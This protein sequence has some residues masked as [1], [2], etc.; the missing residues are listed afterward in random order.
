[1][2]PNNLYLKING[3]CHGIL[4][5]KNPL[6]SVRSLREIGYILKLERNFYTSYSLNNIT[7]STVYEE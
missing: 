2:S 7:T 1:M 6:K 3:I 5:D 4:E